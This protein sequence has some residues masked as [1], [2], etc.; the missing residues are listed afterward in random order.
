[1]IVRVMCRSCRR[2]MMAEAREA[3][4]IGVRCENPACNEIIRTNRPTDAV[5]RRR[6]ATV[7]AIGIAAIIMVGATT[8]GIVRALL[9][10][11]EVVEEPTSAPTPIGNTVDLARD[12][13]QRLWREIAS[14]EQTAPVDT[15]LEYAEFVAQR[16]RSLSI[17][18]VEQVLG[19]WVTDMATTAREIVDANLQFRRTTE[20]INATAG[21]DAA[22]SAIDGVIEGAF[23]NDS[24]AEILAGAIGGGVKGAL[25]TG[26]AGVAELERIHERHR[27]EEKLAFER[28]ARLRRSR[29]AEVEPI[30][31]RKI[32]E[33]DE[34]VRRPSSS[35]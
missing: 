26:F 32:G 30:M 8:F 21:T 10:R 29:G 33:L 7:I 1:M 4:Q 17:V 35:H 3:Y 14:L 34:N 9:P 23:A 24:I 15:G 22:A 16:Y 2:S 6:M 27:A 20:R 25:K 5:P 18:D 28:L 13:T 12:A 31:R 19:D 11:H